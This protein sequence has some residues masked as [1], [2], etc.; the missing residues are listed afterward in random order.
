MKT[1]KEHLLLEA[2][3]ESATKSEELIVF[4]YNCFYSGNAEVSEEDKEKLPQKKSKKEEENVNENLEEGKEKESTTRK[5]LFLV[6]EIKNIASWKDFFGHLKRVKKQ[7]GLTPLNNGNL[8]KSSFN[9]LVEGGGAYG[10]PKQSVSVKAI[11]TLHEKIAAKRLFHTGDGV[12]PVNG[13]WTKKP[14]DGYGGG[15]DKTPKTDLT[16]DDYKYKMSLKVEEGRYMATKKGE[17][18][19]IFRVAFEKANI[20]PRVRKKIEEHLN[21]MM[22]NLGDGG[23]ETPF[24]KGDSRGIFDTGEFKKQFTKIFI[25]GRTKELEQALRGY[26]IFLVSGEPIEASDRQS[27]FEAHAKAEAWIIGI[28]SVKGKEEDL[29]GQATDSR[30]QQWKDPLTNQP[31]DPEKVSEIVSANFEKFAEIYLKDEL[32]KS[33][34]GAKLKGEKFKYLKADRTVGAPIRSI[35][36]EAITYAH[37]SGSDKKKSSGTVSLGG[38]QGAMK[39]LLLRII[40]ASNWEKM[41]QEAIEEDEQEKKPNHLREEILREAMT[42]LVKFDNNVG[43][44][45]YY[46]NIAGDQVELANMEDNQFFSGK[47]S[48]IRNVSVDLKGGDDKWQIFTFRAVGGAPE[49]E[50]YSESFSRIRKYILSDSIENRY[51]DEILNFVERKHS[52]ILEQELRELDERYFGEGCLINEGL[53]RRVVA[54]VEKAKDAVGRAAQSAANAAKNAAKSIVDSG[55]RMFQYVSQRIQ[56]IWNRMVEMVTEYFTKAFSWLKSFLPANFFNLL[57]ESG[58][59]M[60]GNFEIDL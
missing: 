8:K 19:A 12:V 4:A 28:S 11:K 9:N 34:I 20:K 55:V 27:A 3:T 39:N 17:T 5:K 29:I 58:I 45:N 32:V 44:A 42:G 36:K 30:G 48:H 59:E 40:K 2:N 7:Y 41:V 33:I 21:L 26:D 49:P 53:W 25:E 50:E 57:K 18:Q 31:Y 43:T 23:N 6:K 37:V 38:Q 47:L 15:G 24:A 46:L 22:E 52:K 35:G 10:G 14:P 1:L 16:S 51:H 13:N 56:I 60:E 54:G